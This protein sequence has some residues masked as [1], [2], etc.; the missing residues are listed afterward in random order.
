MGE[1]PSHGLS[2]NERESRVFPELQMSRS[3]EPE[4]G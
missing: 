3:R 2:L 1:P 4:Q